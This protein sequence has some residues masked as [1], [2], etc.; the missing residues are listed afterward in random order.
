M[1][2]VSL[3]CGMC[4]DRDLPAEEPDFDGKSR[5]DLERMKNDCLTPCDDKRALR[6]FRKTAFAAVVTRKPDKHVHLT[7]DER[8]PRAN[9]VTHVKT[10][11]APGSDPRRFPEVGALPHVE[12]YASTAAPSTRAA[13]LAASDDAASRLSADSTQEPA[14]DDECGGSCSETCDVN[15]SPRRSTVHSSDEAVYARLREIGLQLEGPVKKYPQGRTTFLSHAQGRYVKLT[16]TVAARSG[17][18]W[19]LPQWLC[20]GL[21]YWTDKQACKRK[22]EP[23]GRVL[24]MRI[25]KVTYSPKEDGK[26]IVRI[27]HKVGDDKLD[28]QLIHASQ[29]EAEN[30]ANQLRLLITTLRKYIKDMGLSA[31]G[32]DPQTTTGDV[33]S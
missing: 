4:R 13:S 12:D 5:P 6:A 25:A 14:H 26:P 33:S 16:T 8:T 15:A 9:D 29:E 17:A 24:L 30:W 11:S 31:E 27:R 20:A 2:V 22:E 10:D 19:R 3:C 32:K 18:P 1:A 23:R 21:A 28:L 7:D